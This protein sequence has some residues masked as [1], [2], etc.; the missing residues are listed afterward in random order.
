MFSYVTSLRNIIM[1]CATSYIASPSAIY[2]HSALYTFIH[3]S[4]SN[5]H[6]AVMLHREQYSTHIQSYLYNSTL[7]YDIQMAALH[8][9]QWIIIEK[10][11]SQLKIST[12]IHGFHHIYT[13]IIWTLKPIGNV[14]SIGTRPYIHIQGENLADG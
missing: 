8:L 6:M 4:L 1:S 10:K 3:L 14:Y 13:L 5:S 12:I 7:N 9:Q 11:V 2:T